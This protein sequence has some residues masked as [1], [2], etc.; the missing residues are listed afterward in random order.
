[1]GLGFPRILDFYDSVR[2]CQAR[3][4]REDDLRPRRDDLRDHVPLDEFPD[5]S[6]DDFNK[7]LSS[8]RCDLIMIRMSFTRAERRKKEIAEAKRRTQLRYEMKILPFKTED[9]LK[10][11]TKIGGETRATAQRWDK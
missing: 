4:Y 9:G 7:L 2:P 6:G 10:E 3:R 11:Q 5:Q 8:I 1:M